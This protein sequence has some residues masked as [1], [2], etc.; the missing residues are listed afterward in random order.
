MDD[1]V[2][3]SMKLAEILSKTDKKLSEMVVALPQYPSVY[4]EEL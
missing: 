3:A 4:E 2:F 1:G